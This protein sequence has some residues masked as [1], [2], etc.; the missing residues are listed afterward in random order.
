MNKKVDFK[1]WYQVIA[2][3]I[4]VAG[5]LLLVWMQT[6]QA[7]IETQEMLRDFKEAVKDSDELR[8][9]VIRPLEGRWYYRLDWE[10]YY[11][12]SADPDDPIRS[13]NSKGI[14]EIRWEGNGEG[15]GKY[16]ILLGY[17][18]SNNNGT[19]YS[20]SV[21]TGVLYT[22]FDSGFP[23]IGN[24]FEMHYSHRLGKKEVVIDGR[25]KDFSKT[26]KRYFYEIE[27]IETDSSGRV[28]K[29]ISN[30]EENTAKGKATFFRD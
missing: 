4:T 13:F 25:K 7:T 2:A 14:A 17:E 19:I 10:K 1:E 28:T 11:D 26:E 8:K 15:K 30:Y 12:E 9:A 16:A 3:V 29:I 6:S 27:R 22:S 18:N 21:N 24:V 23:S 20:V 5:G